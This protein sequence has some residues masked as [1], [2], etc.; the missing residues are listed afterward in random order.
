M[1]GKTFDS[2]VQLGASR[3][4]R[5][6]LLQSAAAVGLGG[7]LTRGGVK[8]VLADCQGR[9]KPCD[10]NGECNCRDKNVVCEKLPRD[11]KNRSGKRCC[12]TSKADC[13]ADCDCCKGFQ[14]KRGQCKQT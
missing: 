11:C 7:L 1:D 2:I 9:R 10:G 14:C 5:R 13:K 12:G 4:G 8:E 6:R 3:T